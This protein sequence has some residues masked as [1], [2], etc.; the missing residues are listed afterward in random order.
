M[1]KNMDK[2]WQWNGNHAGGGG[3]LPL[4]EIP[5]GLPQV[6]LS[7]YLWQGRVDERTE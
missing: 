5:C 7:Y 6:V 4:P 1:K 2:L 3:G